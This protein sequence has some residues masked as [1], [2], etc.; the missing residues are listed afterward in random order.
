M[1]MLSIFNSCERDRHDWATLFRQADP[2]FSV[3]AI[4]RPTGSNLSAIRVL[5][6][7]KQ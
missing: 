2:R 6:E 5:W 1:N 4:S 7:A 3:E